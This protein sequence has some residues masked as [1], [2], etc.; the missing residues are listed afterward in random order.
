VEL[1]EKLAIDYNNDF[2]VATRE[3]ELEG[4]AYFDVTENKKIPFYVKTDLF[5]IKVYGTVFNVKSYPDDE[6]AE[7]TLDKG[8]ISIFP[9]SN[10]DEVVNVAPNQTVVT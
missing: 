8:G 6:P 9:G 4:G 1:K 5:K 7:T 3:V 2:G 10:P